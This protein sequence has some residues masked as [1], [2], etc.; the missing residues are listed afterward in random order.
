MNDALTIV[1]FTKTGRRTSPESRSARTWT[2]TVVRDGV[3]YMS[4]RRW[5]SK[6]GCVSDAA[7]I[8]REVGKPS[9]WDS[10]VFAQCYDRA[11]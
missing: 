8:L 10:D 5:E 2:F 6:L 3:T 9:R 7:K 1:A 11:A 4:R